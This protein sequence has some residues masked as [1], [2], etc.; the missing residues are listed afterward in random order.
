M[1]GIQ[2]ITGKI[3]DDANSK[4]KEIIDA[5]NADAQDI[6]KDAREEALAEQKKIEERA[7]KDE[8]VK[9]ERILSTA[10][11]DG[12]KLILSKKQ[13]ILNAV[14]EKAYQNVLNLDSTAYE[15]LLLSLIEKYALGD[16]KVILPKNGKT[17]ADF[18]EKANR[19]LRDKGKPGNL[20]LSQETRDFDG[21]FILLTDEIEVNCSLADL[22]AEKHDELVAQVS[23]MLF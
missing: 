22:F 6:L 10:H 5:A 9:C 23:E 12:K 4:K 13:E 8:A 1:N 7:R 2:N 17:P 20:E 18:I 15:K 3:I 14:F 19:V 21:G 11:S 16:E